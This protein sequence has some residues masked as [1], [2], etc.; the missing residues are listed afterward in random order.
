MQDELKAI[1]RRVG[2]TFIHV[3]H[4]QEEAMAVADSIVVMNAGRIEDRGPPAR[5]WTDPATLFTAGFMG[6]VNLIDGVGHG[7]RIATALGEIPLTAPVAPVVGPVTLAIR[8]EH[9]AAGGAVDLGEAEVTD[10][11]FFGAHLRARLFAG[12]RE[13]IANLPAGAPP[14][15]VR[16]S[17]DPSHIKVFPR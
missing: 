2:T 9:V 5:V 6:E 8:P 7:D 16:L 12:G 3:T 13:I 14:G 15:R 11:A 17:V 10:A 4:D 1:Q